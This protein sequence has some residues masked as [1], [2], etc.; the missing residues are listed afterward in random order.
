MR[1]YGRWAGNPKGVPENTEKCAANIWIDM[2]SFQCDRK[3]G[4]GPNG[5][6]CKQHAKMIEAGKEVWTP[7]DET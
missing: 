1:R 4:F 6:Y 7:E 3:R 2:R 5:L